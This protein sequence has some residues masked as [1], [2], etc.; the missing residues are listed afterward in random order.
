LINLF[1]NA[2]RFVLNDQFNQSEISIRIPHPDDIQLIIADL[3]DFFDLLEYDI[4]KFH[5]EIIDKKTLKIT[6]KV[7]TD[8]AKALLK[9]DSIEVTY[10]IGDYKEEAGKYGV[11]YVQTPGWQGDYLSPTIFIQ[12]SCRS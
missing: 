5:V 3:Y 6:I 1:P 12:D 11:I 4:G 9:R 8:E 7:E 2:S 10:K